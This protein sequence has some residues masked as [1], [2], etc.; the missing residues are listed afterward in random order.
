MKIE[1]VCITVGF[2]VQVQVDPLKSISVNWYA[3][4][5]NFH[6]LISAES[7]GAMMKNLDGD[8][9]VFGAPSISI[10]SWSSVTDAYASMC[11]RLFGRDI[12]S[13]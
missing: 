2:L 10:T 11:K 9:L 5:L 13:T 8:A 4:F 7:V 3:F 12:I 1:V 6:L